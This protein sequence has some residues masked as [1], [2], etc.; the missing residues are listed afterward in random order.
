M[1]SSTYM[2]I[3]YSAVS[4]SVIVF[5]IVSPMNRLS[6]T[7]V[8]GPVLGPVHTIIVRAFPC[9]RNRLDMRPIT[10]R[11]PEDLIEELD[12]EA[13][14]AGI[15]SRSEYIRYLLANRDQ[16]QPASQSDTDQATSDV[17]QGQK[18]E[19]LSD[20]VDRLGALE[21]RV[22]DLEGDV[23]ALQSTTDQVAPSADTDAKPA[24]EAPSADNQAQAAEDDVIHR[25]E[26]WLAEEGPESESAQA[27]LVDAAKLLEERGQLQAQEL[28][29]SLYE[30]HPDP[31]ESASTLWTATVSRWYEETPGFANPEY[32]TYA[33]YRE[34]ALEEM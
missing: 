32:G 19:D 7:I 14:V 28:R 20:V 29:E 27:I 22:A 23:A 25:L 18:D 33:F 24:G 9:R 2:Q 4:V 6:A 31:Y 11:L 26:E 34:R 30:Q 3:W 21:E 17:S 5:L 16:A 1:N 15:S 10:L 13:D 12:A 8:A